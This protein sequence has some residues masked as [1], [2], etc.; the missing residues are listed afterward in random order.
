MV[1]QPF[2]S[3]GSPAANAEIMP[4]SPTV[5]PASLFDLKLLNAYS[6]ASAPAM[7]GTAAFYGMETSF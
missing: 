3:R 2:G 4:L 1:S 6:H 5:N 7:Q